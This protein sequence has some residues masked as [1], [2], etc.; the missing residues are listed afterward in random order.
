MFR[1]TRTYSIASFMG[2]VL[3]AVALGVFYRMI[4]VRSLVEQNTQ[5]NVFLTQSLSNS[6]WPKYADFIARAADIPASELAS[7]PEVAS[8][9]QD[10]IQRIRGLRVVK[11]KI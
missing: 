10:V 9:R 4:A 3:V 2:I 1:L 5:A 11:V 6:L 8:L 7:Q